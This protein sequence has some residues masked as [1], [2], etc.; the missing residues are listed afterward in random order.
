MAKSRDQ[1]KK[2]LY[3]YKILSEDTDENH[4]MNTAQIIEALEKH[5]INAE[6]KSIYT[7]IEA[8][9]DV[10][11]DIINKKTRPAGYYMA[12]REFEEVELKL[13]V[14][15]VQSSKF[16][17]QNQSK[18]IIGKLKTL[19]NK[20]NAAKLEQRNVNISE[21]LKQTNSKSYNTVDAIHDA[22]HSN[23]AI[24]FQYH[25][26]NIKG[27]YLPRHNGKIYN[28]SPYSLTFDSDKYYLIAFDHDSQG[29]RNYRVDKI[30]KIQILEEDREGKDEFKNFDLPKYNHQ[31]FGMFNGEVDNV[32]IQFEEKLCGVMV[33]RFGTNPVMRPLMEGDKYYDVLDAQINVEVVVSK[34]FYGWLAGL[35]GKAAIVAPNRRKEEFQKHLESIL[36]LHQI[37]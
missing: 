28:V 25:D 15:S 7:D 10:G 37:K 4:P 9:E 3:V 14:D 24:S 12:S 13:L 23:K 18:R 17:T 21:P 2:L 22:I 6:R 34:Q 27:Q 16:I 20:F 30:E 11:C 32:V 35:D 33:D 31:T 8:L 36:E 19:T 5:D 1:K 26:W 29:V